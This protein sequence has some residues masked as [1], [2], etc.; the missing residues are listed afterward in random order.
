M[1]SYSPFR[2]VLVPQHTYI[3]L[4][5]KALQSPRDLKEIQI[6]SEQR[7]QSE[8]IQ[9]VIIEQRFIQLLEENKNLTR[10]LKETF[11]EQA[12]FREKATNLELE[13]TALQG[14]AKQN[15]ALKELNELKSKENQKL[16][17]ENEHLKQQVEGHIRSANKNKS[18]YDQN[19]NNLLLELSQAKQQNDQLEQRIHLELQKSQISFSGS[20]NQFSKDKQIEQLENNLEIL[21]QQYENVKQQL[22][23]RQSRKRQE[24]DSNKIQMLIDEIE[25]LNNL[26]NQR[27]DEVQGQRKLVDSATEYVQQ[28]MEEN[29]RLKQK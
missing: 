9:H 6:N 17:K 8:N 19:V 10:K 3:K 4:Q 29:K 25:R 28:L 22:Q 20:K 26:V 14:I 11:I 23:E 7:Y 21:T 18:L 12:N 24:G 2:K 5:Q 13:V 27:N 1:K 15:I 16:E